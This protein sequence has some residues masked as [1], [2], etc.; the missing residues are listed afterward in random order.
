MGS[1]LIRLGRVAPLVL[2]LAWAGCGDDDRPSSDAG[3]DARIDAGHDAGTTD[4]AGASDA[5]PDGG[6]RARLERPPVLPRPPTGGR[7]PAD[8]FPPR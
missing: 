2:V 8:L 7:L 3:T 5:G 4:D 1:L 6:V